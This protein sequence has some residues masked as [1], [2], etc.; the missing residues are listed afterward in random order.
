MLG[1]IEVAGVRLTAPKPGTLLATLVAAA[2]EAVSN[3]R[4]VNAL[5]P[6][7][8]PRSAVDNLR[9]YVAQVRR[10]LGQEGLLVSRHGGYALILA[11]DELDAGIFDER[12]RTAR[13]LAADNDLQA[14]ART[15]RQAL[16]LWRG[17]VFDGLELPDA[18]RD[19]ARRLEERRAVLTEDWIDLELALGHHR[20]MVG[21]L[22]ALVGAH[23]LRE[24]LYGQLMLA[25]HRSGR[26]AEALEV[27]RSARRVLIDELGL[28]PGAELRAIESDILREEHAPPPPPPTGPVSITVKARRRQ[29]VRVLRSAALALLLLLQAP[30]PPRPTRPVR[31]HP[32]AAPAVT[33]LPGVAGDGV[34]TMATLLP[35]TGSL[36]FLGDAMSTGADLAVQDVNAAGGVL[37]HPVRLLKADS[38]DA[39]NDLALPAVQQ[40]IKNHADVVIG[41]GSSTVSETI[42]DAVTEADMV[43]ISPSAAAS[44]LS[45]AYDRGL[46]F[47]TVASNTLQGTLLGR[48]VVEDGNRTA[49]FVALDDPYGDELVD[50]A[51]AV[52]KTSGVEVV[53]K[54]RYPEDH[55]G[56][57]R[58][59]PIDA[60]ALIMIGFEETAQLMQRLHR[61][62]QRW[63]L[64]DAN[65]HD[66]SSDLPRGALTG[67]RGIVAEA[68]VSTAFKDRMRAMDPSLT[69]FRYAVESYDAVVVAALAARAA[70]G[71][72]G[73]SI[74][75]RMASVSGG[76]QRCTSFA[77][78]AR[79]LEAGA[80][81]DYDGLSGRIE[82]DGNGDVA[83]GTFG[84]FTYGP[85][86]TYSRTA[87]RVVRR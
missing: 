82:F 78:C 67:V 77:E 15:A 23:P 79:L 65:L 83:E 35:M 71:D 58:L 45:T 9:V 33:L 16:D 20:D 51:E 17:P 40:M 54:V 44:M 57:S 75:G 69:D 81:I 46:F 25:L 52:L 6:D 66:Y 19:Y 55:P 47:R 59:G 29:A 72:L 49:A 34:L 12:E 3:D 36:Y 63:Y 56:F 13:A 2:G 62:S 31:Q 48:L 18:A 41:P 21:E 87:T 80:D 11:G 1:P 60:D 28:E 8:M 7:R 42:M 61:G 38:G 84:V 24:R 30:Q 14:A 32:V 76:G 4:L 39:T 27:Y 68:D 37:G 70:G 5:W 64:V 86:N 85:G 73:P 43:M 22:R 50:T 74:A 10:T 26:R 53:K